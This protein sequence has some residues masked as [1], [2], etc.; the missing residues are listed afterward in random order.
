[1]VCIWRHQKHDYANYDQFVQ[2]FGIAG[3]TIQCVSVP[4]LNLIGIM[5][6]S[7]SPK[8]LEDFLLCNM[9]KWAGMHYFPCQHGCRNINVWKFS[10]L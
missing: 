1:M 7:Y 5:K 10:K 9:G 4:N 6:Q 2:N 3:K 8:K